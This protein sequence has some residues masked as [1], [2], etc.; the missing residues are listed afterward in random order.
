MNQSDKVFKR[1][2]KA[3]HARVRRSESRNLGAEAKAHRASWREAYAQ[4]PSVSRQHH[5]TYAER[6]HV[7]VVPA[8]PIFGA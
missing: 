7:S 1:L 3:A 2:V 8:S 6:H 5:S 4:R